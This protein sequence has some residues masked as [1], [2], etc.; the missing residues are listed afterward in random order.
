MEGY[1]I[2]VVIPCFNGEKYLEE[3][4]LSVLNQQ[5]V[6]VS[7]VVV[8]DGSTDNT[9]EVID[10]LKN[11]YPNKIISIFQKNSGVSKA[12]QSGL[13]VVTTELF[14]QMDADDVMEQGI[15]RLH[16]DLLIENPGVDVVFGKLERMTAEG[17][18][19]GLF[20]H[21]AGVP[22]EPLNFLLSKSSFLH[23]MGTVLRTGIMRKVGG[24]NLSAGYQD[25]PLWVQLAQTCNFG[26]SG[27]VVGGYRLNPNSISTLH[28][29]KLRRTDFAVLSSLFKAIDDDEIRKSCAQ[30]IRR[31]LR[32]SWSKGDPLQ[33]VVPA[34]PIIFQRADVRSLIYAFFIATRVRRNVF[35]RLKRRFTRI[36]PQ[37]S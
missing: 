2:S 30:G 14:S 10:R 1:Q 36:M 7:V 4:V 17:Q 28:S 25:W 15:L 11:L 29:V 20:Y 37:L 24:Y 3:A 16:I 34:L 23:P 19:T 35:T 27:A 12:C 6:Q 22:A 18:R 31:R 33:I 9:S 32:E 8:D 21:D 5:G 13:D 26:F